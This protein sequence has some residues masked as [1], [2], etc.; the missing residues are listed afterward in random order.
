M[1]LYME[2]KHADNIYAMMRL[3]GLLREAFWWVTSPGAL[4]ADL[5]PVPGAK[6]STDESHQ[7]TDLMFRE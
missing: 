6:S 4:D 3:K 2:N 7:K 5:S 1:H